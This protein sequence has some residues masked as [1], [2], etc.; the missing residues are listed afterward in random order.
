MKCQDVGAGSF[1]GKVR[2]NPFL[3]VRSYDN[4]PVYELNCDPARLAYLAGGP[5]DSLLARLAGA[6]R[7]AADV[8]SPVSAI[9]GDAPEAAGPASFGDLESA[10]NP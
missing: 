4:S 6:S 1:L 10:I 9:V 2:L 5:L 7:S 3:E 8:G